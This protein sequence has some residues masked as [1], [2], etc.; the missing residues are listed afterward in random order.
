MF[1]FA[2]VAAVAV[3]W[4]VGDVLLLLFCG[5]LFAVL[6]DGLAN[7]IDRVVQL[8]RL[9]RVVLAL[10]FLLAIC[11]G[12]IYLTAPQVVDQAV[13][14]RQ[15]I[16]T[17]VAHLQEDLAR[18]FPDVSL[19]LSKFPSTSWLTAHLFGLTT[20][21]VGIL[22][23]LGVIFFVGLYAAVDP[24]LYVRGFLRLFRP[25][26]R[27]LAKE[28]LTESG[29][30][31]RWWLLGRGIAMAAVGA[32]TMAGLGIGGVHLAFTLGLITGLLT[33]IPYLGAIL[34]AIPAIL[35]AVTQG[36]GFV[37]FVLIIFVV[38]HILEGYVI[39][40]LVQQR[41]IHLP[42]ALLLAAQAIVGSS[43]GV[44]GVALAAPLTAI[45]MVVTKKLYLRDDHDGH[46]QSKP[47]DAGKASP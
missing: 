29:R 18:Y 16:V 36:P 46:C 35:I 37:V 26:W 7:S 44:I 12:A 20:S 4:F 5:I 45:A 19:P 30:A 39:V 21:I 9:V 43:Y 31:L 6:L 22:V 33:F 10:V 24:D 28:V 41:V 1:G 40:P 17:T 3:M 27:Q 11:G 14:L 38:A 2:I 42:P 13:E 34:S 32:L 8:P 23:T 15:N 25:D 47:L